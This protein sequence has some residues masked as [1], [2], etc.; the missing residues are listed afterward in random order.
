M[1]VIQATPEPDDH[2]GSYVMMA[3]QAITKLR[4]LSS[5]FAVLGSYRRQRSPLDRVFRA[6][7]FATLCAIL[8]LVYG[9]VWTMLPAQIFIFFLIPI[10]LLALLVIWALP[11][12]VAEP[13]PWIVTLLM[14]YLVGSIIWPNYLA[15]QIPGLP[16]LSLRRLVGIPLLVIFLISY[17]TSPV[18]RTSLHQALR[19]SK[20]VAVAI[21]ALTVLQVLTMFAS[22]N[23]P[24][25]VSRTIKSWIEFTAIFFVAVWV[26]SNPANVKRLVNLLLFSAIVLCVIAG[27]EWANK[28]V[29]WANY[30]P[31]FLK[32]EDADLLERLLSASV[33]DGQYRVIGPYAVSLSL[34]ECLAIVSPFAVH[35]IMTNVRLERVLFWIAVDLM[36]FAAI[37]VTQS[38]LGTLGW[39]IAHASYGCIWA[40]RRWGRMKSDI[41]APAISLVFPVGA[42]VLFV[43]MFTIPAIRNRTIG[44][45]STSLSDQSR[46]DQFSMMWPKL[47]RNPFGHGT[48]QSGEV[49]GYVDPGG[50]L[51]VDSYIITT[52]LDYGVI[53][54]ILLSVFLIYPIVK[55][56][57]IAWKGHDNEF[58]VALPLACALTVVVEV[59]LVLSQTE[60]LGLIFLLVGTAVAVIH[61]YRSAEAELRYADHGQR[62]PAFS[63]MIDA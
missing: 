47:F 24:S 13:T 36:L 45:G 44:G 19:S 2:D 62:R 29:I 54:L 60:N 32:I 15:F 49:L 22:S 21:I 37:E 48:G 51:T 53:G 55:L 16:W 63:P 18:L 11:D 25:T 57:G 7:G 30:I 39:I 10:A 33:R 56:I 41:I 6:G 14:T 9:V 50:R 61:R 17:S 52:L 28:G 23:V 34:A 40:F 26:M 3:N 1:L 59:R 35:K 27:L 43:G 58:D 38:R 4:S 12:T 46:L 5:T 31:S 8:G 20:P 42:F